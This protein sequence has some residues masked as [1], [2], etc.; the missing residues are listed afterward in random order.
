[1]RSKLSPFQDTHPVLKIIAFIF[2]MLFSA[3]IFTSFGVFLSSVIAGAPMNEMFSISTDTDS[4][5][6][7]Q[8]ISAIGM[9]IV[10][11]FIY[12]Y[13]FEENSIKF[14]K[15]NKLPSLQAILLTIVIFF[16][17]NFVL[18][19]LVKTM[20]L[21]PFESMDN[22]IINGLLQAEIE[23]EETLKRFLDFSSPL[24]FI[25]VFF[26]M[27]ILPGIGEELTFRGVF[28]NL[29]KEASNNQVFAIVLSGFVFAVI[30]VQLHNFLAIFFM[31]IMLGTIYYLTK[32]LWVSI[33]AHLFNNGLIVVMSYL[34]NLGF[35]DFDF[36]KT[37]DM[38]LNVSIFG[39]ILFFIAFYFYKEL[40]TKRHHIDE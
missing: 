30:H 7:I 15:L 25:A 28:M 13:L 29:F 34:N 4:L 24:K 9:F 10:P 22:T 1:M 16:L 5:I 32:N 19:L 12:T 6:I 18:D 38:P 33:L 31:G 40:F 20:H 35:V 37:D 2:I 27:A 3:L 11:V 36:S 8:I 26:M 21:I 39:A 17:A 23:S 14:L